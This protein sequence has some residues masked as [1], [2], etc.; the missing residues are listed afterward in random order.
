MGRRSNTPGSFPRPGA[1]A[2]LTRILVGLHDY[3]TGLDMKSFTVTADFALGGMPAGQD[4]AP[5]FQPRSQGVWEW[6]L[7]QPVA[8]L[9]RG[10]LTVT[11]KDRQGNMSRIE[12][13]FSVRPQP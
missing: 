13:T 9:S 5:K 8:E 1:Q 6:V 11:I 10:T 2:K 4:L 3:D 7:D 12:R